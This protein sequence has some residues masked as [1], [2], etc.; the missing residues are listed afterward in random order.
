MRRFSMRSRLLAAV[1]G[2]W[3]ALVMAEPAALHTCAVHSAGGTGHDQVP[4]HAHG[5]VVRAESPAHVHATAGTRAESPAHAH[6]GAAVPS[7]GPS[8]H[9]GNHGCTCL[10]G[11]CP[12][13]PTLIPPP[14]ALS[15]LPASVRRYVPAIRADRPQVAAGDYVL[16]FANGPPQNA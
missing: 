10:G 16:P 6:D 12:A 1:L 8:Q 2:P 14:P 3:F 13:S 5:A 15:W 9:H 4:S 7:H 11:C